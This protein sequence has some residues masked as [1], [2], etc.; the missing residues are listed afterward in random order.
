MSRHILLKHFVHKMLPTSLLVILWI[1]SVP[2]SLAKNYKTFYLQNQP[3]CL[4]RWPQ[5]CWFRR[6]VVST[7]RTVRWESDRRWWQRGSRVFR[8]RWRSCWSIWVNFQ[9]LPSQRVS[10]SWLKVIFEY[11]SV[12]YLTQ[13]ASIP[14]LFTCA[15][16]LLFTYIY[17]Y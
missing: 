15:F 17:W 10:T 3:K 5:V 4:T 8:P 2:I 11:L 14:F 7:G 16:M 12:V 13:K 6:M 9:H 1:K